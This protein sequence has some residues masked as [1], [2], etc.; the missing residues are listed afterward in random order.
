MIKVKE[1]RNP[2]RFLDEM[3][4]E[5][6]SE[7]DVNIIDIKYIANQSTFGSFPSALMIYEEKA[8]DVTKVYLDSVEYTKAHSNEECITREF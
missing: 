3:I 7:N 2:S 4:N 8:P 5:F 1:F 6:L